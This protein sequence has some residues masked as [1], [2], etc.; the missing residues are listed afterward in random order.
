VDETLAGAT[1]AGP[2]LAAGPIRPGI[3][4]RPCGGLFLVGNAAGEA[5]P[6]VAEG[7]S[8]A[9]QSGWLLAEH[10]TAWRR[11]SGRREALV[12]V[13]AAYARA[14]RRSFGPRIWTA[15]A[16]AAW[17]MHPTAVA[18][19]LP[20]LRRLPSVLTWGARFSGKATRVVEV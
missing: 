5:H 9:M 16:V 1:R 10:L 18:S 3:R 15:A 4:V 2:W 20:L 12:A 17:A 6:V 8:M 19:S 14:W 13:G 7:I 11:R